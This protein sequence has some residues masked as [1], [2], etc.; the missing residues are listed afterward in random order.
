MAIIGHAGEEYILRDSAFKSE[1]AGK[2]D[3]ARSLAGRARVVYE[4]ARGVNPFSGEPPATGKNPQGKHGHDHS[5]P[6][7][8]SAF[9]H[10]VAWWSSQKADATNLQ[11]PKGPNLPPKSVSVGSAVVRFGPWV[12]WNRPHASIIRS[13]HQV[14]PYSRLF[15]RVIAHRGAAGNQTLNATL[16]VINPID[17]TATPNDDSVTVTSATPAGYLFSTGFLTVGGG[18]NIIQIEFSSPASAAN[19]VTIDAIALCQI[20]KRFH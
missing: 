14:A 11:Q 9:L 8:G 12:I 13:Q 17:G 2:N 16:S 7:W 1:A 3:I 6:P 4:L 20:K 19:G 15:L 10:P 5:G 18:R